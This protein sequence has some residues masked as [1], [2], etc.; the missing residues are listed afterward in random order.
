MRI[1]FPKPDA[2]ERELLWKSMIVND[3]LLEGEIDFTYLGEEFELAG[4]HIKNAVLRAAFI[5]ASRDRKIDEDLLDLAARIEM[6]EQGM[7]VHGNPI[8]ELWAN[9]KDSD[10]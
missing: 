3:K 4:G 1:T 10:R 5:A 6:K 7:L 9:D 2:A 8:E